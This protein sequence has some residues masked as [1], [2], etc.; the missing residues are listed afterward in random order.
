VKLDNGSTSLT[1]SIGVAG[2][3]C[4][5]RLIVQGGMPV[6]VVAQTTEFTYKVRPKSDHAMPGFGGA[7]STV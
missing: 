7:H 4:N 3:A 2:V 5:G 6:M 1:D